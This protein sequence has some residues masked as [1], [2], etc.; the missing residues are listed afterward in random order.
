MKMKVLK[1]RVMRGDTAALQTVRKQV[2]AEGPAN[3]AKR[4]NME[5]EELVLA[6]RGKTGGDR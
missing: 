6:L 4:L 2:K 5:P 3:V 1:T